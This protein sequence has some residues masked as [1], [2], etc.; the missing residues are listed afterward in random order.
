MRQSRQH[1]VPG[2]RRTPPAR[3]RRPMR[4]MTA[5]SSRPAAQEARRQ[6]EKPC[7]GESYGGSGFGARASGY[8]R[9]SPKPRPPSPYY[10]DW[11]CFVPQRV[12]HPQR[13]AA[14]PQGDHGRAAAPRAHRDHRP[15]GVGEEHAGVRHAVRPRP[16][17]LHRVALGRTP[18]S[19]STACPSPWWTRSRG[20][21]PPSRS[22]RE[23]HHEQPLDRRTRDRRSTTSE[24]VVGAGR[25]AVLRQVWAR[26][27]GSIRCRRWWDHLIADLSDCRLADLND[28]AQ[29]IRNP[30]SA[31]RNRCD[32]SAATVGPPARGRAR[33]PTACRG[34][35]ASAARRRGGAAGT[36]PTRAPG[37]RGR[38]RCWSWSTGSRPR[39][40]IAGGSPTPSRPRSTRVRA[41]RWRSRTATAAASPSTRRASHCRH[42]GSGAHAHPVL[43]H[44]PA[45]RVP[46]V[47]TDFGAV[48]EYDESL[49]VPDPKRSLV[50]GA[51]D[52]WT[53]PRYE[54]RRR[55]LREAARARGIALESPLARPARARPPFSLARRG[56][57]L[58]SACCPFLEAWRR[59]ATSSTIRVFSP[60]IPACQDVPR[61]PRRRASSPKALAVRIGGKKHRG[62][63]RVHGGGCATGWRGSSCR[64]SRGRSPSTFW[65]SSRRA[66]R[67]W[68]D[69]GLGY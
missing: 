27:Q 7:G 2:F 41:W 25:D 13:A 10:L 3:R 67:S 6:G 54:G 5:K 16:A 52:P 57:P 50:Q 37:A 18:S 9:R 65:R 34:V 66:S 23:S 4:E 45:W 19:S 15:V 40:G 22:S 21:R 68:N 64:H 11:L 56:R 47:Q 17:P 39:K 61:L 26:G 28:H 30:K 62:R 43:L 24:A 55:I 35:R 29:P 63:R 33:R 12:N 20:F 59:S 42:A 31:I 44:N 46:W 1:G 36:S 51:L 32:L 58:S 38:K 60:P 69:V 48:L 14:Q 8:A 49:I 53:K